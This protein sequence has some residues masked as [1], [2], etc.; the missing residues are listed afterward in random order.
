MKKPLLL[1][2][3]VATISLTLISDKMS[4]IGSD[5]LIPPINRPEL[6]IAQNTR[7]KIQIAILLDSSNSMDGLIE[8]T[9]T[10]IWNIVNA[11]SHVTKN[12]KPPILEVSLYHYG[13]DSLPSTEGFNRLL[14]EF[15]PE[16]DVVSEKL[17][18]I[19]TNGGQEYT[20][21]VI[22]SAIKQLQWSNNKEDFRVIFIAGNEGFDQGSI[23]WQKAIDLAVKK[24]VLVNT[25]YCGNSVHYGPRVHLKEKAVILILIKMKKWLLFLL[26]LMQK[27][28]N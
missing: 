10:K 20:G 8:Q 24:D 6:V 21:W 28:L 7:P 3:V 25:I 22:D 15:T 1:G 5:L 27:L 4:A 23:P 14:S 13:N 17:F 9:R 18:S 19:K 2:L 11:I 16:L 12:G 26:H